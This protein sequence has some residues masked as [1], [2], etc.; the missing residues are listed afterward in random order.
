MD[1]VKIMQE[2]TRPVDPDKLELPD[3]MQ[4]QNI[5]GEPEKSASDNVGAGSG[6][7][8]TTL[9]LEQLAGLCVVGYNTISCAIY[10][11]FEP[12]FD[13]SLTSDEMQAIQAPLE[14][15]LAQYDV[16]V[17]PVTALLIAV[18]GVNIGK[19]MALQAYR[20]EKQKELQTQYQTVEQPQNDLV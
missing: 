1:I 6:S 15:V 12:E 18:V 17:T 10:R 20:K 2:E 8:T 9:S 7:D 11:R 14:Q 16:Q 13:A 3:S 4:Q 19:I 5:H